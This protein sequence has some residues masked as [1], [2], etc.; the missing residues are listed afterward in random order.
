MK[1]SIRSAGAA[2]VGLAL[3]L[4]P[5]LL[6]TS[7]ASAA[8]PDLGPCRYQTI[9]TALLHSGPSLSASSVKTVPSGYNM[10]GPIVSGSCAYPIGPD[11]FGYVWTKV[12]CAAGPGGYAYV[13]TNKIDQ[14]GGPA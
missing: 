5:A 11:G 7:N 14:T 12:D 4:S 2:A 3:A 1:L 13:D 9:A 8:T 10:T 6:T